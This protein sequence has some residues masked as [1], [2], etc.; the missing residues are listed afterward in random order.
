MKILILAG[1]SNTKLWPLSRENYP[2]QFLKLNGGCS[3]LRQTVEIFLNVVPAHDIVVVTNTDYKHYITSDLANL[4]AIHIVLEPA[5]RNTTPAIALGITYCREKLDCKD[6]EVIFVSPSDYIIK[7][8]S[9]FTEYIKSTDELIKKGRIVT[10]GI[11]PNK[12]E[13]A[14]RY[15]KTNHRQLVM[16]NHNFLTVEDFIENPSDET[17]K[18]YL[19]EGSYYW[20][21]GMY[22]FRISTILE[23]LNKFTPRVKNMLD[24]SLEEFISKFTMIPDISIDNA[25]MKKSEKV[26]MLPIDIYWNDLNSW[27][28]LF[29]TFDKDENGN[30]TNGD[31]LTIDTKNTMILGNKRII[32]TIGLEDT[33]I[34]ETDDAMLITKM[35]H[36]QRVKDIISK[37]KA[38]KRKE[39]VEH[40]TTYRPW[41]SYTVLE[42]GERYKIKR[43]VVKPGEK[44]SLQKH[45]HRS[46]HWIV[47]RGTAKVTIGEKEKFIH[48]NESAYVS[49]STNHRVEN[50]GK[51]PIEIIEVQSGEYVEEDDIVRIED[52]YKRV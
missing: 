14:R 4:P 36:A 25:V 20:H 50:P 21:L 12:P 35:G 9:K 7:P 33:L 45:H 42:E 11:K 16:S 30:V 34:V 19:M 38:D 26:A 18:N 51:I 24:G 47:V 23:E 52:V 27:D 41:G 5:S 22:T 1:G 43:I 17:A 6:D 44:L 46:E 31:I 10:F 3:L 2:K 8:V 37:L 15:I 13:T 29:E 28:A 39:V 32:T 48:E 49:K 40:T